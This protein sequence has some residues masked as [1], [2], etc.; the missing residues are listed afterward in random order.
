MG[1]LIDT[2]VF[3]ALMA[4]WSRRKRWPSQVEDLWFRSV[5]STVG[6]KI[7]AC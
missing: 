3:E 7:F 5:W 2:G 6:L 4:Q 1:I